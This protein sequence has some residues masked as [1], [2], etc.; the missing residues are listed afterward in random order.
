MAAY[1]DHTAGIRE[2]LG[3]QFCKAANSRRYTVPILESL[4]GVP[5]V[6]A[7]HATNAEYWQENGATTRRKSR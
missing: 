3:R 6:L 5:S 1:T 2:R 7:A 4:R